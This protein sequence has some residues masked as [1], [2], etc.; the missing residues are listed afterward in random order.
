LFQNEL[1]DYFITKLNLNTKS[2]VF[3][4]D[5]M[6]K[7]DNG[8]FVIETQTDFTITETE[9]IPMM[10]QDW[11]NTNQP[12]KR[13]DLQDVVVPISIAVRQTQLQDSFTAIEEFRTL[14]NGGSDTID[15]LNV[16]FRVSQPSAPSSPIVHAGQ[17]WILID[18]IVM[19]SAG[20]NLLYGNTI[21]FKMA[22]NGDTLQELII[23]TLDITTTATTSSTTPSFETETTLSKSLETIKAVVFYEDNVDLMDDLQDWIWQVTLNQK[24]D[25]SVKYSLTDTRTA[26]MYIISSAQ[27]IEDGVPMGFDMTLVKA[28]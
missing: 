6:F 8:K 20:A 28:K 10:I 4:G 22:K 12:Y 17:R 11:R 16:G 2:L 26:T 14:L 3:N 19:L 25:I 24:F 15:G 7:R 27:H 21:E 23:S 5:Y 9:Y 1:H 13:I 18:I